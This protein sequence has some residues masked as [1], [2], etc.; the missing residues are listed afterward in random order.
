MPWPYQRSFWPLDG[1]AGSGIT[2]LTGDVTATG[3]GAAVATI[4]VGAVTLAKMADIATNTVIGRSTAGTGSPEALTSITPAS[5]AFSG[6]AGLGFM[7]L[8]TQSSVPAAP[9]T[10]FALYADS[11]GKLSWRRADGNTRTFEVAASTGNRTFTLPDASFTFAGQNLANTFSLAQVFSANGALSAP[12]VSFTGTPVSGGT[13]ATT[14]PLV[15]IGNGTDGGYSTQG[16]VLGVNAPAG[17]SATGHVL[18]LLA[19]GASL[20][21]VRTDGFATFAGNLQFPSAGFISWSSRGVITSPAAGQ[22]QLGALDAAAPVS[23][24]LSTQSVVA[25]TSNTAGVSFTRVVSLGTGTGGSGD[26]ILQQGITGA[27]GTT[28][29]TAG[30]RMYRRAKETTL[31]EATATK[32]FTVP[33]AAGGYIGMTIT[34][35]VFASDGTDHQTITSTLNVNAVAKSTTI[36]GTIT[37]VDGTAANSS[38][39]LTPVTYT[40]VDDGSN[41]LSVKCAATSSL[42]QTV[43]SCKWSITMLNSNVSAIITP[44]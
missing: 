31:T 4:A 12:A 11:A 13:A 40:V 41:V 22:I 42:T 24:K 15:K 34:A 21:S 37:Q 28:Q 27:S 14:V 26:D 35:T 29:N 25:G 32:L 19:N 20:L 39:T 36:T 44:L 7:S 2:S 3:P 17:F 6:T 33:L 16:T 5:A 23:Q 9:A 30:T 38:G 43:L 8:L 18:N 1:G 10:G